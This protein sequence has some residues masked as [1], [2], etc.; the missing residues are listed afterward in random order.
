MVHHLG[1]AYR[2]GGVSGTHARVARPDGDARP[3]F[4]TRIHPNSS[5]TVQTA[6]IMA[7][8][9]AVSPAGTA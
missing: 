7:A 1:V 8:M 3:S 9:S 5:R 6:T 2:A 4:P